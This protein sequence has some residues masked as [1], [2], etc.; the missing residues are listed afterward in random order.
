MIQGSNQYFYLIPIFVVLL[1]I[2]PRSFI[3][4]SNRQ[5][6]TDSNGNLISNY[7]MLYSYINPMINPITFSIIFGSMKELDNVFPE[8]KTLEAD[9]EK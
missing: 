3:L 9:K 7:E 2:V 4:W 1:F 5:R 8:K 6:P